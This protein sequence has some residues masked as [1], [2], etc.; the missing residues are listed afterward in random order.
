[1]SI[2]VYKTFKKCTLTIDFS[3]IDVTFIDVRLSPTHDPYGHQ[4]PNGSWMVLYR[5][6]T[7]DLYVRPIL[8]CSRGITQI[9]V[10]SLLETH[11]QKVFSF[12]S[13]CWRRQKMSI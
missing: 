10:S 3:Y 8:G 13:C 6:S 4:N 5:T 9:W 11:L 12:G 2:R 1:M 7:E